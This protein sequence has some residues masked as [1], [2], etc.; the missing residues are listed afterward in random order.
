MQKGL[1]KRKREA[2]PGSKARFFAP[3]RVEEPVATEVIVISPDD[4]C[5]PSVTPPCTM[6]EELQEAQNSDSVRSL[7]QVVSTGENVSWVD[8]PKLSRKFVDRV[9]LIVDEMNALTGTDASLFDAYQLL[10]KRL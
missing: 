1:S 4:S 6:V 7:T 10:V 9:T 2:S 5:G 8:D 3:R